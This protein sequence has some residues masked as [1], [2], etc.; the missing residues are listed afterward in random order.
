M[1][2][3]FPLRATALNARCHQSLHQTL[4]SGFQTLDSVAE[5]PVASS[6]G[7]FVAVDGAFGLALA[8]VVED[9]GDLGDVER[10]DEDG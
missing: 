7:G 3:S 10:G 2:T 4:L 1:M 9:L 6:C 8:L 5:D